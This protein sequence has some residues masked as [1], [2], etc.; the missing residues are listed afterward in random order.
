MKTT[1]R[2]ALS[3]IRTNIVACG[4]DITDSQFNNMTISQLKRIHRKA[5]KIHDLTQD[6][7]DEI[8]ESSMDDIEGE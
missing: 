5:L 3:A 8:E 2:L 6:I 4:F 7:W 1:N